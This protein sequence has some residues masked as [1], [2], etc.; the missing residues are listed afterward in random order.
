MVWIE[1]RHNSLDDL[2]ERYAIFVDGHLPPWK[3]VIEAGYQVVS[4]ASSFRRVLHQMK[5]SRSS[6]ERFHNL[7]NYMRLM[8]E[9]LEDASLPD[10]IFADQGL[11]GW[12]TKLAH[13]TFECDLYCFTDTRPQIPHG[14]VL[15]TKDWTTEKDDPRY[16]QMIF[17]FCPMYQP[18]GH[19]KARHVVESLGGFQIKTTDEYHD[20]FTF[21]EYAKYILD[22]AMS[23]YYSP[24]D[25]V[26]SALGSLGLNRYPGDD[27]PSCLRPKQRST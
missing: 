15:P 6:G 12:T 20:Y 18:H 14:I 17:S 9:T 8:L 24:E 3:R 5:K 19:Q 7:R 11:P 23:V 26:R 21:E 1:A 16:I 22:T 4:D 13:G 2:D 10:G 27:L 25:Y